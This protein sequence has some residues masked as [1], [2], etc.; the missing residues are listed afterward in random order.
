M[1][2]RRLQ[3]E[4]WQVPARLYAKPLVLRLGM[5]MTVRGFVN[6]LNGLK[7]EE[8]DDIPAAPG[9]FAV[10]AKTVTF[11]PAAGPG[12]ALLVEF[13]KDR[14]KEMRGLQTKRSYAT[15][16]LEPELIT[17]LFDESAREEAHRPLRGVP[18]PP[19]QGRARDRGPPLLQPSRPRSLPDRGRRHAQHQGR[20]LHPGRQH[21]HPAAREEL[22]PHPGE[23]LPAQG[24]GGAPRLRAR[25]ARQQ[26]GHPRAVPQRDLPRPGRLVQHQRHGRGRADVLPQGRGQPHP[27]GGGAAGGHDPVAESLQPV[28]PRQA[29]HGAP[30]PG[31]AR[32]A[33]V[34]LRGR[35][36]GGGGDRP[37]RA[38]RERVPRHLGRA[39]LRGPREAA[40]LRALRR[41]GPGHPEPGRLHLA[42]PLAAGAW[43]RRCC[44][45]A[46]PRSTR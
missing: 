26:E 23:E 20:D 2:D 21:H 7:Y 40:A 33:G 41:E 9:E 1:V 42:R 16:T 31:A 19:H 6:V 24:A 3:G 14:V 39:V 4:R 46:W 34:G 22:L 37:A 15:L 12:E 44:A 17:Y 10:G 8:K 43:P 27:R 30:Q 35:G 28:P 38:R 25:A 5:P 11:T 18:G 36:H 32:D 45:R 13:D 29:R